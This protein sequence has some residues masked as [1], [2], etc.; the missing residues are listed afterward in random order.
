MSDV[1]NYA[2]KVYVK[3]GLT[4]ESYLTNEANFTV[5]TSVKTGYV[6]YNKVV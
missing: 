2:T 6:L 3:E 5:G 1:I 4:A